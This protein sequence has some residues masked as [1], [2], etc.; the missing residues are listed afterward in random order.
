MIRAGTPAARALADVAAAMRDARHDWWIIGSAAVAL[1]GG[2]T[3]LADIDLLIDPRDG[4]AL[5][6]RLK[7]APLAPDRDARFRSATFARWTGPWMPVEIMAD[8][9]VGH[10][11]GWQRVAPTTRQPVPVG[12]ET[13]Y[14]PERWEMIALLHRFGRPK[15]LQ[16]ARLLVMRP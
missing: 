5:L 13:V 4:H 11:G 1:L 9:Y 12:G 6:A 15:D 3:P 8:L 7:V 16:R 10:D 14:V 2:D